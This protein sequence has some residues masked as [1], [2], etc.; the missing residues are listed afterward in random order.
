M[1][2]GAKE[3]SA[4]TDGRDDNERISRAVPSNGCRKGMDFLATESTVRI[5]IGRG[6]VSE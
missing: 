3:R 2:G 4:G 5:F 1:S 6:A